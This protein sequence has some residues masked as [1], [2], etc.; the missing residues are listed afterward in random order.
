MEPTSAHFAEVKAALAR[1]CALSESD[2]VNPGRRLG[3]LWPLLRRQL[4]RLTVQQ[5]KELLDSRCQTLTQ[6]RWTLSP[7]S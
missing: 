3:V 5:L 7:P 1:A 4:D 6:P 2:A